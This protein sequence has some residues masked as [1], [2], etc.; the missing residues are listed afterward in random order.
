MFLRA[1]PLLIPVP[2]KV[3]ASSPMVT[4]P[5]SSSAAPLATVTPPATVPSAVLCVALKAPLEI[6]VR[7]VYEFAPERVQIPPPTLV[8][9]PVV[10][11]IID[12]IDPPWSPPSV[13]PNV[14]PVMM[15]ALVSAMVPVPPTMELAAVKVM[16]PE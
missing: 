3:K 8:S 11:P 16:R 5:E 1:P 10:V 7:P 9:V 14:A 6:V 4:P 15:P 13:K 12:A 2:F